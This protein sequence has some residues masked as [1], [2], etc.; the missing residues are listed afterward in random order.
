[1][2]FRIFS[3]VMRIDKF[4]KRGKGKLEKLKQSL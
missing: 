1:V 2:R 4:L 3:E